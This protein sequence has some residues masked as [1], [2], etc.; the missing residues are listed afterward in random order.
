VRNCVA[1]GDSAVSVEP[2][3]WTNLHLAHDAIDRI[4][5]MMPD[6]DCSAVELWDYNRQANAEADR[7]RDFLILH[8]VASRRSEPFWRAATATAP[9][10]SLAHSLALFGERGRLPYYE[11]ETFSRDS[12]LAVLLGQGIIPRRTDPLID[13]VA[14][15]A[16]DQAMARMRSAIE[17]LVPT[18][19]TQ[20]LY[21]QTL[22]RQ[23]AR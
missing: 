3:E 22:M 8:Y 17:A 5:A 7:V 13:A 14:P 11:E 10:A 15:A 4:V 6:R 18:L 23:A 12:W 1:I 2:L 9:P 20:I 19:P 21:L 16:A